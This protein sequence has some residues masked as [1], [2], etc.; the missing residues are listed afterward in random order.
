[1]DAAAVA[2]AR[3][4]ASAEQPDWFELTPMQAAYLVGRGD[5][6]PLGQVSS[7]VYHEF[8]LQDL[9]AERLEAG[10][11]RVVVRHAALRTVVSADGRQRVLEIAALPPTLIARHDARALGTEQAEALRLQLRAEMAAQVAPL[12]RPC[13]VDARLI[14]LPGG[15]AW[16]LVSHEGLQ[17]DGLS[18][19]ILFADWARA[20]AAPDTALP[21]LP[22]L[23][24]DHV[25]ASQRLRDGAPGHAARAHWSARLQRGLPSPP[26]LPMAADPATL[27]RGLTT[28]HDVRLDAAAFARFERHAADHGVTTA[29]ALFAAYAEVLQRWSGADPISLNTT[30]ADRLPI[31]DGVDDAIGNYTV[32]V[33]VDHDA[34]APTFAARAQSAQS[35]LRASLDQRHFSAL[36]V[37]RLTAARDAAAFGVP[38]TFNCAL[39]HHT[40]DGPLNGVETL[41]PEVFGASQTPQVWMNAFAQPSRGGLW[42]QLD[43]V[44]G[45][46]APGVPAAVAGALQSLLDTLAGDRAAWAQAAFDLLPAE[47]RQRRD[48]ANATDAPLPPGLAHSGFV[49]QAQRQPEAVALFDSGGALSYGE[50]HRQAS[51]IAAALAAHGVQVDEPVAIVLPKSA[52]QVAAVLGVA[53]SGAAYLPIDPAWPRA[54]RSTLLASAGARVVLSDSAHEG[55]DLHGLLRVDIDCI[56]A[57]AATAA[58]AP[59]TRP[60]NLAYILY[61]SGSTGQ[62]KGVAVNH[63]SVANLVADINR[64]Y[65]VGAQDRAFGISHFNFDLSVYDIFGLLAAGGAIVLPDHDKV[66]DPAHWAALAERHSV[67]LWNSVPAIVQ[68][69]ADHCD[70]AARALPAALR[71]VMMSGDRIPPAL[72]SQLRRQGTHAELHS[73]GGPTETTVWNVCHP[74]G[75]VDPAAARIPYGRPNANNRYHVLDERLYDCP[76]WVVGE[77]Y[78]AGVGLARGY[79]N[80][81]AR[82][83]EAFIVHPRSGERLYR[84]GD[85]GCYLPDGNLEIHGRSDFQVKVNG[86][87]VE[88]GEIEA[89]LATHPLV[90][91]CAVVGPG[92]RHAD[93]GLTAFVVLHDGAQ[94]L[95][96]AR[97]EALH[98]H[99]AH[100]LPRCMLPSRLIA[101]AAL[102][103]SANAKVDR[104]QLAGLREAVQAAAPPASEAASAQPAMSSLERRIA[105]LW[106]ELLQ[107]PAVGPQQNFFALG[108]DSMKAA[109]LIVRLRKDFALSATLAQV[110]KHPTVR[111]LATFVAAQT[112][113][114]QHAGENR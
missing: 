114:S 42:L 40:S 109:R 88:L 43:A 58:P 32:P 8:A 112:P 107:Q 9:P 24:E 100:R 18:M 56:D 36:D 103:L 7:H 73:L 113:S 41:G 111:E 6:L 70:A 108:G 101:L 95:S 96:A 85:I 90:H 63:R 91:A 4:S 23:F 30:L 28:R 39:G 54:R 55:Q 34:A 102:P 27:A 69:L 67:T 51:A 46:F 20:C 65:R 78:A 15:R 60:E 13:A 38:Y 25:R 105:Q 106:A 37:A 74:I 72:P 87:R 16:L 81:E 80:D 97:T 45:L 14:E 68:M 93:S 47:Q 31:D 11:R 50:L 79:W 75:D 10:L 53:L 77:L 98:A 44:D 22:P 59:A 61:T 99:L 71:L 92:A 48:E 5:Q 66:A 35:A 52:A 84:T 76:D 29:A 64:R 86:H 89:C 12:N 57:E 2:E 21:A 26:R 62:P 104:R 17:I 33:L 49:A 82:T 94:A 1:M 19:Q 3:A 110:L 83:R